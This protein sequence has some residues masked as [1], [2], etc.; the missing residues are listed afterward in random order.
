MKELLKTYFYRLFHEKSTYV[1]FIISLLFTLIQVIIMTIIKKYG[2]N[3]A[4]SLSSIH[5]DLLFSGAFYITIAFIFLFLTRDWKDGTFRNLTL[6][7]KS[8]SLIFFAALI[9]STIILLAFMA[10]S[11]AVA[12]A[13]GAIGGF[14]I[15][16]ANGYATA[17]FFV[18]WGMSFFFHLVIV[19][20]AV[21]FSMSIP[22]AFGSLGA[23]IGFTL[24]MQILSSLVGLLAYAVA[25]QSASNNVSEWFLTNQINTWSHYFSYGYYLT[26]DFAYADWLY[27]SLVVGLGLGGVSVFLSHLFF[28]KRDLK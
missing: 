1:F 12:W 3:E 28:S 20:L 7:G 5:L 27:K 22:S 4:T 15:G 2:G 25:G 21:S 8:R 26:S 18:S 23:F 24:G 14:P 9:T 17:S 10:S 6:A 16:L 13:V 11:L 19:S